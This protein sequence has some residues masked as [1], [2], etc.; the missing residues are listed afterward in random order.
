MTRPA[1][2]FCIACGHEDESWR[3]FCASCGRPLEAGHSGASRIPG[4]A[5]LLNEART[6]RLQRLVPAEQ[7]GQ[8]QAQYRSELTTLSQQASGAAAGS[9]RA[10]GG[11]PDAAS[12]ART[13]VPVAAGMASGAGA[14]PP[15]TPRASMD[16][17]WLADQQANLFLFAGAFLVVIAALIYVAYSGRAISGALKMSL[18]A[19]YTVAFLATGVACLRVARVRTAGQVFFGVGALLVPLNFVAAYNIF[20]GSHLSPESIWLA[21]SLTT[22][23]FYSAVALSG[24]GRHYAY[25]AGIAL[26]S[27]VAAAV[28]VAEL[29]TPWVAVVFLAAALAVSL[30]DAAAPASL[31]ERLTSAWL[32]EARAVAL[33]ASAL[34]IVSALAI[35]VARGDAFDDPSRWFLLP[36]AAHAFAFYGLEATVRRHRDGVTACASAIAA[37]GAGIVFGLR[38]APEHY[39]LAMIGA[40][41]ATMLLARASL[42]LP[43]RFR[44][45]GMMKDAK[46]AGLV[47]V[48]VGVA[49]AAASA[50]GAANANAAYTQQ[51]RWSLLAAFLAAAFAYAFAAHAILS[52]RDDPLPVIGFAG[53]IVGVAPAV[54]YGAGWG[55]EYYAFAFVVGAALLL[56]LSQP[57]ATRV[58]LLPPA[59]RAQALLVAHAAAAAGAIV[60]IG[61]VYVAGADHGFALQ[62]RWSAAALFGALLAFYAVASSLRPRVTPV[63]RE[64]AF[65]A[66]LASIFGVT[67]GVV[68]ALDVAV[69]YYAFA[70]LVPAL[71]LAAAAHLPRPP[72][73]RVL[74]VAAGEAMILA[75]RLAVVSGLAVSLAVVAAAAS[76]D[77]AYTLDSRAFL[78][79]AFVV[80]A[81]FLALDGIRRR[82]YATSLALL[83]TAL[84]AGLGVAYAAHASAAW[85]GVAVASVGVLYGFGLPAWAPAWLAVDAREHAAVFTV[86]A[87]WFVFEGAYATTA[88]IA[89]GVHFAASAYYIARALTDGRRLTL[90]ARAEG[91]AA[92]AVAVAP[93]WLYAAGLAI[94]IGYV[95]ALRTLPGARDAA[96]GSIAL[97]LFALAVAFVVAGAA[98][99]RWRPD[100]RAHL[101]VV[102]LLVDVAAVAAAHDA[103]MLALVLTLSAAVSTALAVM[104]DEPLLGLPALVAGLG[105]VAAWQRAIAAPA[106]TPPLAY[107]GFGLAMYTVGFSCRAWAPRWSASLRAGGGLYALL[108]TPFGF[109]V[110]AFSSTTGGVQSTLYQC[111]TLAVAI[112]GLLALVESSIARRG[113]VVVLASGV[114]FVALLLEIA[115]FQPASGQAY[116]LAAGVYLVLLGTVGLWRFRLLPDGPRLAPYVEALGAVVIMLPSFA[117]SFGDGRYALIL[118]AEAV[119]S[120]VVGVTLRRRGLLAT[121]ITAMML[122]A[123]RL[124]FDAINA[125]PNWIVVLIAG[126]ALLGV[127]MAIL[128]GRERWER[129]QRA[130]RSWWDALALSDD[131]R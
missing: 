9:Q 119:A 61:A 31:R 12:R 29:P 64:D 118:L 114:L 123:L 58:P 1:T 102:A 73:E 78:P 74:P 121:A 20:S 99:R 88:Q 10:R 35:G 37:T 89:A 13:P 18:L 25:S 7:L 96:P 19:G 46:A 28:A 68:Y 77:L 2:T 33:V 41:G 98:V 91:A 112:V 104:E 125:L 75:G 97:P 120:F 39:A 50:L 62:T 56:A 17:N 95:D 5:F 87:S 101:Y 94:A 34:A 57:A 36:A 81:A 27:A 53:A 4:I 124:L 60:M 131:A 84:G 72:S 110:L 129:W 14:P 15:A 52:D 43:Y 21:G 42:C 80:A 113:W 86:T 6:P 32:W 54:V 38:L 71:A 130:L 109:G 3:S 128:L 66:L 107:A 106:Y 22:A 49:V 47:M 30:A 40:G 122:V 111:S 48:S 23:L 45:D 8:L 67:L 100:F 108:A 59:L 115:R 70:L 44:C 26:L 11:A 16:W 55:A 63:R 76:D 79:V 105:A 92:A 82:S 116:T 103:R 93:A 51:T 126:M 24:L 117:Q 85:Y 69:E 90:Q 65:A 83:A 127:G